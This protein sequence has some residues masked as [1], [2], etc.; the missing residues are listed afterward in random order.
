MTN[1]MSKGVALGISFTVTLMV[2]GGSLMIFEY[3]AGET[4]FKWGMVSCFI[5]I[6]F[7]AI[8][9]FWALA[10]WNNDYGQDIGFAPYPEQVGRPWGNVRR[11][12]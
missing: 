12:A 2:I 5:T 7:F 8:T 6:G 1:F 10:R 3:D 4:V 9:G 11:V